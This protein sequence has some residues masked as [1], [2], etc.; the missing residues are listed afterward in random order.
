MA[1]GVYGQGLQL[2]DGNPNTPVVITQPTPQTATATATLTIAQLSYRLLVGNPS[3]T[4]ATYTTPTAA[5][6]DTAFPN[7]QVNTSFELGI[8]NLGTSTGTITVAGGTGVTLVGAGLIAV[9]SSA[10]LRF[11]KTGT[12]AWTIYRI[13]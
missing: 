10:V 13:V 6:L 4:A 11:R 12:G 1:Y 9:T 3:T 5:A 7:A 8:I 2:N